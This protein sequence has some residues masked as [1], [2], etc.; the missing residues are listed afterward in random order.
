MPRGE[1]TGWVRKAKRRAKLGRMI[2]MYPEAKDT[3]LTMVASITEE[4]RA[5]G[6]CVYC[7]RQLDGDVSR[8]L[9]LGKDCYAVLE[10]RGE[11]EKWLQPED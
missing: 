10:E 7:G 6:V 9:G 1:N 5:A 11:L 3:Y 4:L 2:E 8:R